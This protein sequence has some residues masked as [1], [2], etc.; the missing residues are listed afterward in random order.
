MWNGYAQRLPGY[1]QSR[2]AGNGYQSAQPSGVAQ[3]AYE[4]S[5]GSNQTSYLP[6]ASQYAQY[7]SNSYSAAPSS[8]STQARYNAQARPESAASV[9]S[10]RSDAHQHATSNPRQA[11][12][13]H[14]QQAASGYEKMH[15][16][17]GNWSSQQAPARN[18]STIETG[19]LGQRY[20]RSSDQ[21]PANT[22][23]PRTSSDQQYSSTYSAS[24][25]ITVDPS[26]VYD[27][28]HGIQ[29]ANKKRAE[30]EAAK[31][32]EEARKREEERQTDE[33]RARREMETAEATARAE[34]AAQAKNLAKQASGGGSKGKGRKNK[35]KNPD[36][37]AAD[38]AAAMALMASADSGSSG[39]T[40][41][42]P[43][44]HEMMKMFEKMREFN[45]KDPAMLSRL[46]QEE[47]DRHMAEEFSKE[48]TPQAQPQKSTPRKRTG[49]GRSVSRPSASS[50]KKAGDQAVIEVETSSTAAPAPSD[51]AVAAAAPS[52]TLPAPT[53][54][55]PKR[56]TGTIWLAEKKATIAAT[57]AGFVTGLPENKGKFLSPDVVSAILD[58]NPTYLELYRA[59]QAKGF[60]LDFSRFAKHILSAVPEVNKV[61]AQKPTTPAA[62]QGPSAQSAFE[63]SLRD[64]EA[65]LHNGE[66]LMPQ[67]AATS[68][69]SKGTPNRRRPGSASQ[70]SLIPT[71]TAAVSVEPASLS[72]DSSG[73]DGLQA[74]K[75]FVD[76][77]NNDYGGTPARATAAKPRAKKSKLS[78]T[79]AP[80]SKEDLARKRTF[81]DLI[82]LTAA[83]EESDD[84]VFF[85]PPKRHEPEERLLNHPGAVQGTSLSATPS[86]PAVAQADGTAVDSTATRPT[87]PA[88]EVLGGYMSKTS[89]PGMQSD[90]P[91]DQRWGHG[92]NAHA[93][94]AKTPRQ[95]DPAA[96]YSVPADHP[97]RTIDVV[98][99]LDGKRALRRSKYDPRTIARDVLLSCGRHPEM[100]NLNAH[101]ETLKFAFKS[102]SS[103]SADLSTFRWD[104]VDPGGPA[105]GSGSEKQPDAVIA[106]DFG[107]GADDEEDD[108]DR[109]RD[110]E[111][112]PPST[113]TLKTPATPGI[114]RGSGRPPGLVF[115]LNG[116]TPASWGA[117]KPPTSA[118][119]SGGG[120]GGYKAHWA[121]QP[122]FD[123]NGNPIKRKGRPPGWRKS[124]QST[125]DGSSKP[126]TKVTKE[127]EPEYQI[128]NCEWKDCAAELHNVE[129]LRKHIYKKHAHRDDD[130]KLPCRWKDCGKA[131][132]AIDVE[133]GRTTSQFQ[134]VSFQSEDRWK[135]HVEVEHIRSI[136]WRLGDGPSGGVS[137]HTETE[138]EAYLS[139]RQG[140]RVTPNII[141]PEDND[142]TTEARQQSKAER[143]ARKQQTILEKRRQHMGPGVDKGGARLANDKRRQ[144]LIDSDGDIEVVDA[145][146]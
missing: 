26:Q 58:T 32:M 29:R 105:P 112:A 91:S 15:A 57:A 98:Q 84:E 7:S 28:S 131:R 51:A 115:K 80:A 121:L 76:N 106:I 83:N 141:M 95:F 109:A 143:N 68:R 107:D 9:N 120:G 48:A 110:R 77:Q 25:P 60:E 47:R 70:N 102:L 75:S 85:P 20:Q 72:V 34:G 27:N 130:D 46:W 134:T 122:N 64:F 144:G 36:T 82:D 56:I 39:G 132:M 52:S 4:S 136:A 66:S 8:S 43:L 129:T 139:D 108:E 41:S 146:D 49:T 71:R 101:L 74:V 97:V 135:T 92:P 5:S 133:T 37:S 24:A 38:T 126:T 45:K 35:A 54:S 67:P 90:P 89:Q 140:R 17:Q 1:D 142:S 2:V 93:P 21:V 104:V 19:K 111:K 87:I 18:Q 125:P 100:R 88:H 114:R 99:P 145:E 78:E 113:D 44:E 55:A 6:Q 40:G 65:R 33:A 22:S 61:G 79:P 94:P 13:A 50:S 138:S 59:I 137:D 116:N 96:P 10:S 11:P 123:E 16:G 86:H 103:N 23:V 118:P 128:Y 124:T 81:S 73:L 53:T 31:K 63:V 3:H 69:T 14:H 42:T 30:A 117:S 119:A 127:P 62:T 12:P